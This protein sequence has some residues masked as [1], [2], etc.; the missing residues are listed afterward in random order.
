MT[1]R[2]KSKKELFLEIDGLKARLAEAEDA[3]RA[4]RNGEVDALIGPSSDGDRIYTLQGAE[5]PYRVFFEAMIEGAVTMTPGGTILYCNAAFAALAKVSLENLPGMCLLDLVAEE[6]RGALAALLRQTGPQNPAL[7]TSLIAQ[8]NGK[9]PV[10]IS[11]SPLRTKDLE[12]VC[13]IVTDLSGLLL[14][15]QLTHANEELGNLNEELRASEE[16]LKDSEKTL[17]DSRKA[18]LNLMEDAVEARKQAEATNDEL[19]REVAE[20][21]RAEQELLRNQEDLDRAQ[22][23]GNLGSWRLD[24]RRN[25]LS[26]SDENYRIFGIP[27]G[28]P[29]RYETFLSFVHP[30]DRA[31]V[32]AQW[33][34]ALQGEPYDLEHRIVADK[35]VKWVR[36]K[37]Y[38][39][40]D[41]RGGLIGG[42]GITQDI[43]DRKRAEEALQKTLDSLEQR[44]KER[45]RELQVASDSVRTERQRLYSVLETLPV[46]VILLD[47]DYRIPF[48]NRFFRERFGESG[49]RRCYEYLFNRAEPCETCETYT[50]QK[51]NAPHHWYWTGP[52]KRD[53]DI[54]DFPFTD[55]DGSTL[56]LEM[57]I[58]ITDQK[59]AQEALRATIEEIKRTERR[60]VL[61][62]D[63]LLLFTREPER[64]PFLDAAIKLIRDWSGMR[65]VGVRV[66]D[67]RGNIPYASCVGFSDSF[68]DSERTLSLEQDH[69]A[70]TRVVR[71]VPEPQD[72]PAMTAGGSFFSNNTVRYIEDMTEE[73][74]G[75]FRGVC[76]RTGFLSLAVI[77]IRYRDRVLGAIHIAD[78]REGMLPYSTVEFLEQVALIIGE[79]LYRFGVEQES[80]QLA[81]AVESAAD[82]VVVTEPER[83]TI[84]YVND[85]F[86]RMTGYASGEAVGKTIHLLDSGRH[87]QVFFEDL[88]AALRR[89]GVWRGQLVNMKKDGTLYFEDCTFSPA[90]DHSGKVVNF[91]SVRRDVTEK[92]RLESIAESVSMLDNMGAVFAGVRHEI[93]N[94]IN[95]AKIHLSVLQ[96]KMDTMPAGRVREY[97]DRT[98]TE[99]GRVEHLLHTLKTFNLFEAPVLEDVATGPLIE[100]FRGLVREDLEARGIALSTQIL[101]GAERVRGNARALQ[102]VLLNLTTNAADALKDRPEP[103]IDIMFSREYDRVRIRVSD[104]GSGMNRDNFAN[105]FKPFHT[106]KQHGTGLGLVI[107]KK[108]LAAMKGTIDIASHEGSGTVATIYLPGGT[109]A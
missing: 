79:A 93:G 14:M 70:C 16:H 15:K 33:Q 78:E 39:E 89:D 21:K 13:A 73:Q 94:P 5:D 2:A 63:L 41:P 64:D 43:S 49:G 59:H 69:C 6:S 58:D 40:F 7:Q 29:L 46:Y 101:P 83:G 103:H 11:L 57:G 34:K 27:R 56:I 74:R 12:A 25:K 81:A 9:V 35:R 82:A 47:K 55:S 100:L 20:R 28:T 87:D 53:Y 22:A 106:T 95:N 10:A 44:V 85:A 76:I 86:E 65:H 84:L 88:R 42:F 67:N 104:N 32:D 36:E 62:N 31:Q 107:V 51:T 91:V 37:A 72:L 1:D 24:I 19:R 96:Q 61:I 99:I 102:H 80:F 105:L 38:L 52:D 45:T 90:R 68:L 97:V 23:V 60:T 3:L 98:L 71:G 109:H 26:W 54:Y 4:I 92:L 8:G 48:A 66:A 77:P 75:R 50:V 18:A 17:L 30:D 108:M